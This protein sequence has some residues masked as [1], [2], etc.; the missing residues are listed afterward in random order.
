MTDELQIHSALET[1]KQVFERIETQLRKSQREILDALTQLAGELRIRPTLEAQNQIFE[2]IESHL[3][4][5]GDLV[6]GQRELMQMLSSKVQQ[7]SQ[8]API[9]TKPTPDGVPSDQSTS[10]LLNQISQK[11]DTLNNTLRR[12][13]V[14]RWIS[15]IRR[16][17]GFPTNPT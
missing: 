12:P 2:R 1:H 6:D 8:V 4:R 17:F 10:Q 7:F 11:L 5:H 3:I 13:G 9:E 15:E 14:Y 16:W